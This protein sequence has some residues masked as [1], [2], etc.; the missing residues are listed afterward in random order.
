MMKTK[1]SVVFLALLFLLTGCGKEEI[2]I[3][4]FVRTN[5]ATAAINNIMKSDTG[6]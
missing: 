2:P 5:P 6:Y 1:I 3:E 4:D